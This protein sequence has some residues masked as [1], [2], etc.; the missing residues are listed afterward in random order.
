[1]RYHSLF[2]QRAAWPPWFILALFY[3]LPASYQEAFTAAKKPSVTI[4]RMQELGYQTKVLGS[5]TLM[6]LAF[7]QNVFSSIKDLRLKTPGHQPWERDRRITDDWL[8][9][10]EHELN[11][12]N[13]FFGFLF[14]NTPTTLG[15]WTITR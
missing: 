14:Y 15:C 7:D 5:V 12:A 4:S 9:F 11:P 1:M 6:R 3:S 8:E 10:T 13:P 2:A